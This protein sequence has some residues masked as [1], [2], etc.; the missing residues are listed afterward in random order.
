MKTEAQK[1]A[2]FL[3][4]RIME[5]WYALDLEPVKTALDD[6]ASWIGGAAG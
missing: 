3:T 4:Q 6:N 5:R 1:Q 2:L